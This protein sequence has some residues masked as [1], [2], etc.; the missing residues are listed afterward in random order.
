V[1]KALLDTQATDA[2]AIARSVSEPTAFGMVFERHFSL[3]YRFLSFRAGERVAADLA[4]ETFA[5]AFRRRADYDRSRADARPWLLGIAINLARQQ[6]RKE[7][8]LKTA[9]TRFPR[10]RHEEP[11]EEIA[12]RLDAL[13][14]GPALRRLLL[15]LSS[16]E[17]DLLI[18]FASVEFSY[19]EIA[20]ALLLPIG[21][22][23]S[24][25]HRLR[26]KLRGRLDLPAQEVST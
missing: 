21:T 10:E 18:L 19:Q 15:E 3:V 8:R 24:R 7:R 14:S 12:E 5:V 9:M 16:E 4:S 26:R 22:V 6:W 23:R 1:N 20:E 13:A 2:A 25:I 17:L 11:F